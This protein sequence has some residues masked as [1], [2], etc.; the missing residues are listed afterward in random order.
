MRTQIGFVLCLIVPLTSLVSPVFGQLAIPCDSLQRDVTGSWIALEPVT[1]D[2]PNGTVEVM[3][4][5]PVSIDVARL[6]NQECP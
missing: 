4:G 3:P 5:H 6:L 1:V 2:V